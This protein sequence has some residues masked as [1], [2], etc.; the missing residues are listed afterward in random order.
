MNSRTS[1]TTARTIVAAAIALLAFTGC[2]AASPAAS[3]PPKAAG[4]T[5]AIS[6]AWVKA[7]DSGMTAAFGDL[8]NSGS[9][10]VTLVAASTKAAGEAQ[11]HETVTND[12]GQQVM[13]AKNGGF[14]IAAGAALTLEP[15]G[16][17]IMLMGLTAPIKAGDETTFTLTF[18]D[19]STYTF[20][21]PAKD[22]AGAN[23]NYT[24]GTTNSG[25]PMNTGGN[26]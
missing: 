3:A 21:A 1:R 26:N 15:G 18:S 2:S 25:G 14:T 23:E 17:H 16:N 13:R 19:H 10:S 12:A 5:V 8:K 22:F 20:G 6:N 11:L 9:R 4:D 24:G 7:A